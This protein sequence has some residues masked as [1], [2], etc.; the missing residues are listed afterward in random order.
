[1]A[2]TYDSQAAAIKVKRGTQT[3]QDVP[4]KYRADVKQHLTRGEAK[5]IERMRRE[6]SPE[7]FFHGTPVRERNVRIA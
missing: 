3:M 4:E 6:K 5:M 7:R 2:K 1:M